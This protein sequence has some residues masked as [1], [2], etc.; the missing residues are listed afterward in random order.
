MTKYFAKLEIG[1]I[2]KDI[3]AVADT[4]APTE[5]D[6][7]DFLKNTFNNSQTEWVETFKDGSQRKNYAGIGYHY[8]MTHD[9]FISPK[10]YPSWILNE[11]TCRWEAPSARPDDDK[12]YNWNEE[13]TSWVEIT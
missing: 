10:P 12:R 9:A 1:N 8:N 7:I 13:T 3:I 4:D 2:V 5:Q 6:G 11:D